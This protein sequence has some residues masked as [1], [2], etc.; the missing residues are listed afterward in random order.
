MSSVSP[1]G[2]RLD[3]IEATLEHVTQ[4]LDSISHRLDSITERH[5]ALIQSVELLAAQGRE[6]DKR[7]GQLTDLMLTLTSIVRRHEDRL[8]RLDEG[9]S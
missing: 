3:R 7:I 2:N 1:N 8:G 5:E 6:H 4:R 9:Q